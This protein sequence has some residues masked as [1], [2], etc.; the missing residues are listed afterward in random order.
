MYISILYYIK[1][2]NLRTHKLEDEKKHCKT[3]LKFKML[4]YNS[5]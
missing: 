1:L 3:L 2:I 5:F 4:V